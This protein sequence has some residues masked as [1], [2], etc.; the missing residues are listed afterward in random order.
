LRKLNPRLKPEL[1]L[2]LSRL[3]MYVHPRLFARKEE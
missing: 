3:H 2:A 1:C